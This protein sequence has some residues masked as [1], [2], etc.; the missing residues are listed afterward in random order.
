MGKPHP[1]VNPASFSS[2]LRPKEPAGAASS[3]CADLEVPPPVVAATTH[4]MLEKHVI[5]MNFM[6]DQ[7][8]SLAAGTVMHQTPPTN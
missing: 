6:C 1:D 7:Q 8:T 5:S 4:K 2:V 3:N